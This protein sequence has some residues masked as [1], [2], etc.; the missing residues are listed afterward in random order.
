[1]IKINKHA[2][3]EESFKNR[4]L[5]EHHLLYLFTTY[6]YK[7]SL[8]FH[9]DTECHLILTQYFTKIKIQSFMTNICQENRT[10]S[11]KIYINFYPRNSFFH[12]SHCIRKL[13]SMTCSSIFVSPDTR[14]FSQPSCSIMANRF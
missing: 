11:S 12:N 8:I 6:I 14:K 1:M 4:S 3:K 7:H 2:I 5:K 10:R 13:I 9:K